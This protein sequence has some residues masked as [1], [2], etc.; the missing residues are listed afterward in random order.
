MIE[1]YTDGAGSNQ[2]TL[3][4]GI[5]PLEPAGNR[6]RILNSYYYPIS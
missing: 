2:K 6:V 4:G 3:C 1:I 5:L